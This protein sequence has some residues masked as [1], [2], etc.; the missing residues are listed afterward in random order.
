MM[1][2]RVEL[3]FVAFPRRLPTHVGGWAGKALSTQSRTGFPALSRPASHS[4]GWAGIMLGTHPRESTSQ[5]SLLF[6]QDLLYFDQSSLQFFDGPKNISVSISPSGEIVE[7]RSV[8]LTCSCDANPPAQNYTWFKGTSLVSTGATYT[9]KKI[10]SVDSGEY[11]CRSSN[12]HGEKLS[13]ALTLNVLYLQVEVP[14]RVIEGG[15]VTLT[16]KTSFSLSNTPIFTWYRNWKRLSPSTD[17]LLLQPVSREDAGSYV[18]ALWSETLRSP[19]V[20][21]NVRYLN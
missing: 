15:D 9:V 16:C 19:E 2:R 10:S 17:Q 7:G 20:P 14:E 18:C 8:T 3:C 12:E 6:F 4:G 1:R 21:L 5:L 13:A 11:R